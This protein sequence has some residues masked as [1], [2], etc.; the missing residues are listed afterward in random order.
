TFFRKITR[1]KYTSFLGIF[2][3]LIVLLTSIYRFFTA[4]TIRIRMIATPT[5]PWLRGIGSFIF[6][7]TCHH[8]LMTL[9]NEIR[10][11]KSKSDLKIISEIKRLKVVNCNNGIENINDCEP[12][13][14]NTNDGNK[15]YSPKRAERPTFSRMLKIIIFCILFSLIFYISFG[16][17]N[18]SL[19]AAQVHDNIIES[20]PSDNISTFVFILYI[21]VMGF[22][23]PLQLNPCRLYFLSMV[24]IDAKYGNYDL[25]FNLT[26]MVLLAVTYFIAV[27][28]I[29]LGVVYAF[30]GSSASVIICL[31]LP[32]VYFFKMNFL[33]N[34]F[35]KFICYFLLC[36]G[37]LVMFSMCLY[38]IVSG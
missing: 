26:T 22:S 21:F 16:Y 12:N 9:Q 15:I 6:S 20:M 33:D 10:C 19:Y 13:P 38:Y 1:L 8:N 4:P 11:E 5:Y 36:I 17:I 32:P 29:D 3:V 2:A 37:V 31:I 14:F 18:A 23:Y 35:L 24:G 28:G 27:S 34:V 30:I 25:V 7:F